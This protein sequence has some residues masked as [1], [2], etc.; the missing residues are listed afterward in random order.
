MIEALRQRWQGL[1]RRERRVVPAAAIL[2]LVIMVWLWLFEPAWRGR[3]A[4]RT[5]LP[6]LLVQLAEVD[7]LAAVA[8]ELS[9]SVAD[10]GMTRVSRQQLEAALGRASLLPEVSVGAVNEGSFDL[11][12]DAAPYPALLAWL[13][14]ATREMYVRVVDVS[15]ERAAAGGAVSGRIVLEAVR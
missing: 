11:R 1:S 14:A 2:L 7:R 15:L 3:Q 4:L 6:G 9:G 12:L 13:D 8:N 5:Q 10:A